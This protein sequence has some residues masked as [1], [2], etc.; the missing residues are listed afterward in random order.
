LNLTNKARPQEKPSTTDEAKAR[1]VAEARG[2]ADAIASPLRQAKD[3]FHPDL[4]PVGGVLMKGRHSLL[5]GASGPGRTLHNPAVT[6]VMML[7]SSALAVRSVHPPP[8]PH[9]HT[10]RSCST[11]VWRD[12]WTVNRSRKAKV[13]SAWVS[14]VMPPAKGLAITHRSQLE[15]LGFGY[16]LRPRS[17]YCS[18][19]PLVGHTADLPPDGYRGA[20]GEN[21]SAN[22]RTEKQPTVAAGHRWDGERRT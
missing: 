8:H 17:G 13:P 6:A 7:R 4:Q 14:S 3:A 18:P 15:L 16:R 1:G 21:L 22:G 9:S 11:I 2:V 19:Y 20:T 12:P 5:A 10:R